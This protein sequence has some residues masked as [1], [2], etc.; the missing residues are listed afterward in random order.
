LLQRLNTAAGHA[1]LNDHIMRALIVFLLGCVA[2]LSLLSGTASAFEER[3][4]RIRGEGNDSGRERRREHHEGT[5]RAERIGANRRHDREGG[6]EGE[7]EG[8]RLLVTEE[9]ELRIVGEGND[10]GR[11]RRHE[12][13][14]GISRAE[15]IG[16]RRRR[17]REGG[18]EGE[19]EG[20]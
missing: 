7:G 5:S 1:G 13:H 10:S 14:K 2:L 18:S 12:R 19:G 11:E 3:E 4:L 16:A 15:R 17:D 6:S 8:R 20:N 9:R